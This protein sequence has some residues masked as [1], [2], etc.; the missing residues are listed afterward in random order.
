MPGSVANAVATE[1]LPQVLC[2]AFTSS[3]DWICD[4]NTYRNGESQRNARVS[5]SRKSWQIA[6]ALT[7]AQWA[8]MIAFI[9]ARRHVE[10]FFF[11]DPFEPAGGQP[12]GSNFDATGV[13]TQG[14]YTVVARGA[15][16][17]EL[18]IPRGVMGLTLVEV[19]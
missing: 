13:S 14:R 2:R 4:E 17:A 6:P 1:V 16:E 18:N 19:A 3:R 15:V 5:T 8:T 9:E 10:A 12:V 11:Y 7:A